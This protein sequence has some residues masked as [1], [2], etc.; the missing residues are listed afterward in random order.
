MSSARRV[1][2][3]ADL[4]PH[5][6]L[7]EKR[8]DLARK[9]ATA[10]LSD[11]VCDAKSGTSFCAI[12]NAAVYPQIPLTRLNKG[13]SP[14]ALTISGSGVVF[15]LPAMNLTRPISARPPSLRPLRFQRETMS[16]AVR[17]GQSTLQSDWPSPHR[18][19]A[20][21]PRTRCAGSL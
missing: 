16:A 4:S 11:V 12:P 5:V 15:I 20:R 9:R 3:D 2:Q 8:N 18:Y 6:S 13:A 14:S 21:R 17:P 19:V 1:N 7:G 10:S